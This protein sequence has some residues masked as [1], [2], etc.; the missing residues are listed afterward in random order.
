MENAQDAQRTA[1]NNLIVSFS[2]I[3]EH[4][5]VTPAAPSVTGHKKS[6]L[7]PLGELLECQSKNIQALR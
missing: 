2:L 4:N 6:G 1:S 3:P 5:A 7:R